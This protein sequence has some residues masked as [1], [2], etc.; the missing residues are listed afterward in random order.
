[1]PYLTPDA[2]GGFITRPL[3]IPIALAPIISG[4][5]QY[6]LLPWMW[7]KF[8][9]M[10]VQDCIDAVQT[11]LDEYYSGGYMFVGM[12]VPWIGDQDAIPDYILLCDGSTHN[13]VDY[14]D[15]YAILA[16]S[17]IDDADTFHTPNLV[18]AFVMGSSENSE[19]TG[20]EEEHTLTVNEMP[21]HTHDIPWES[22]FPYGNI[23]EVTVTGG[24][25]TT[26]TGATGGGEAHNNL[27]PYVAMCYVIIAR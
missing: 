17:Y 25:L 26:Q 6:L 22:T 2:V 4:Q 21:S 23:P 19:D 16:S 18:D 9:D 8:G 14:P 13:R 20:G 1:M 11:M 3:H 27:P 7:E 10:T 12:I 5:L 15:L 24:V